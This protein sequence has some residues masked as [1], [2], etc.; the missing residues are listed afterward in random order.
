MRRAASCP[1]RRLRQ[2]SPPRRSPLPFARGQEG[3]DGTAAAA[4][5]AGDA[6]GRAGRG[7]GSSPVRSTLLAVSGARRADRD[8]RSPPA[9]AGRMDPAHREHRGRR[10][11]R[12]RDVRRRGGAR[13]R[14]ARGA[15]PSRDRLPRGPDRLHPVPGARADLRPPG[16]CLARTG[17][18]LRAGCGHRRHRPRRLASPGLPAG[19][20]RLRPL[21]G[22]DGD[23]GDY[24][25]PQHPRDGARAQR[26]QRAGGRHRAAA[27]RGHPLAGRRA[28]VQPPLLRPGRPV[29]VGHPTEEEP[30]C[31]PTSCSRA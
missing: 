12:H 30:R 26:G 5:S 19:A 23:A 1:S 16:D 9:R 8:L 31:R 10:S 27:G 6:D 25:L 15:A 14:A 11:A 17:G 22:I 29:R 13:C 4:A 20:G 2:P 21:A 28:R 24:L 3:H 18:P 7:R